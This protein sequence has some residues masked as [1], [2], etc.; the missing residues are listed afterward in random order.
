[1][2]CNNIHQII[3]YNNLINIAVD[4]LETD[5]ANLG[6]WS[7]AAKDVIGKAEDKCKEI[8]DKVSTNSP[9]SV[10]YE[11]AKTLNEKAQT[12][13]KA[14]KD[15]K[16]A[17]ELNVTEA[18][19]VVVEM[20][21]SLKKDLKSVKD[22]IKEGIK[23]K[24]QELGVLGL[25]TLVKSDLGK[26]KGK[27]E[28]LKGEV[29]KNGEN[30]AAKI[31]L[32]E[33][34]KA[35]SALETGAVKNIQDA[36]GDLE[37]KF[38]TAIQGPLNTKVQEVGTAIGELGGKFKDR[39]TATSIQGIFEH[40]KT[41]VGK[42]KGQEGTEN[43]WT[44]K[45]ASGLAGIAQGLTKYYHKF[46]GDP[47]QSIVKGWAEE[48]ILP[49]NVSLR[50]QLGWGDLD[51]ATSYHTHLGNEISAKINMKYIVTD[52]GETD[53]STALK[54]LTPSGTGMKDK[55]QYVHQH[56]QTFAE[57]MD[58]ALKKN[59]TSGNSDLV[60]EVK[61]KLKQALEGDAAERHPTRK[62][63]LEKALQNA[64]EKCTCGDCNNKKLEDC[65]KCQK[66][67]CI[68]SQVIEATLS[69][70][71]TAS[72]QVGKELKSVLLG[73]G[74]KGISIAELLDNAQK[75]TDDLHEQLD[76]ATDP[77]Q[78]ADPKISPAQAVDSKLQAVRNEWRM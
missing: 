37:G 26:L 73:E 75:T 19:K 52:E 49:F 5:V 42:I 74:T 59:G 64:A 67:E 41:K 34:V 25:D 46:K 27:I 14:A 50:K 22:K 57:V 3:S 38:R 39:T 10:I 15:A 47:F 11:K 33:L 9:G 66:P 4:Y 62:E 6:K 56:C 77:N 18:L 65:T 51:T 29:G 7:K 44:I 16:L 31:A 55:I 28:G 32:E 13:L 21:K 45:D 35:K 36:E 23:S 71:S 20:D 8:L 70:L 48:T 17:V 12:L 54:K 78:G 63:A 40:I 53:F 58:E 69:A 72:R 76:E 68:I 61:Q 2:I 24:I 30:D 1:M 60:N 43:G